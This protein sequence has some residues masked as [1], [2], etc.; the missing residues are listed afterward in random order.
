MPSALTL[1]PSQPPPS[2]M[3]VYTEILTLHQAASIS[4]WAYEEGSPVDVLRGPRHLAR[5]A[6]RG[7]HHVLA[8]A[9][10]PDG[11]LVAVSDASCVRLFRVRPCTASNHASCVRL[12]R[13][14]P[15]TAFNDASC[16]RLF[17]V[18]PCTASNDASCV[19]LFRVR[20][21]ITCLAVLR[22]A[23]TTSSPCHWW[24]CGRCVQHVI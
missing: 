1:L 14:R 4:G 9:A 23:C 6:I 12:F 22:A 17:R 18:R 11:A 19:R 20:L 8:A 7:P 10:S 3:L 13:V 21:Y 16:V 24:H 2:P 15:C 5:I